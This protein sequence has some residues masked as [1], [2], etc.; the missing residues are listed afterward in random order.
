MGTGGITTLG[1]LDWSPLDCLQSNFTGTHPRIDLGITND[2]D[3]V[4]PL[5]PPDCLFGALAGNPILMDLVERGLVTL[6]SE[7]TLALWEG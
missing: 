3:A 4:G 5:F 6:K 1:L 2:D 7:R